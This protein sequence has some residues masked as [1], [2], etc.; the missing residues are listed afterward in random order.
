MVNIHTNRAPT[1][2]GEMLREEFLEPMGLT[3]Q[4]LADDI[5]VSYQKIADPMKSFVSS[6]QILYIEHL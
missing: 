1:S 5:G 3:Q 4:Q 6:A 2:P